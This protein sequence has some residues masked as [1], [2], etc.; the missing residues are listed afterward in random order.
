MRAGELDKRCI[1]GFTIK[2][3]YIRLRN[4]ESFHGGESWNP[5]VYVTW[6][7]VS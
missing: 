5:G 3:L 4:L 6:V 2:I 7:C 1:V